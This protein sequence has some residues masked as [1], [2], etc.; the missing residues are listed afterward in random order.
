MFE[1][2]DLKK[3]S[4]DLYKNENL[5]FNETSGDD[6]MRKIF[7]E[8]LGQE[9]GERIDFYNWEANKTKVFQLLS[10]AVDAVLPVVLTNQLN[11]LAEVRNVG[12]GD[13]PVF[14]VEDESLFRVGM[15][16]NGTQDLK[17]QEIFGSKFTVDTDWFG[18]KTFAELERFLNGEINWQKL[19]QRIAKSF[20]HKMQVQIYD[21][22]MGSYDLLRAVRK[23]SGA[24][25]EDKLI[26][27]AQHIATASGGK[28]VAVYGTA[29]A[30][31]KVSKA[32]NFSDGMRDEMNRV[33]YLG[34]VAG[35]D[36]IQLPQ[37]YKAGK[38]EFAIDDNTL[39]VLPQGEKVVT[40]VLE[41]Q[42]IVK[43][44]NGDKRNDMQ[45]EFVT[46]KKYGLQVA[47]LA[48]YGMYKITA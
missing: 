48:V 29:S 19:I 12:F 5:V 42:S 27:M 9:V 43:E 2:N 30:L 25:D 46:M 7:A 6:A 22:F 47:Q 31:R 28:N 13:R 40:I 14:E 33:G 41:G 17:R 38:E 8:A 45:M 11:T 34:T 37:A 26:T 36:L 4:I 15:V 24:Y 16:A 44:D 32:A 10:V 1:A 18:A 39:I 20:E 23:N 3:L 21:A 35:L